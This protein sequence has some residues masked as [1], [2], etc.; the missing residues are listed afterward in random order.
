MSPN[1]MDRRGSGPLW[2]VILVLV[3]FVLYSATIAASTAEDCGTYGRKWQI[4]PPEWE[5]IPP[6]GFG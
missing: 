6:P 1:K 4:F 5:C 2:F 3:I